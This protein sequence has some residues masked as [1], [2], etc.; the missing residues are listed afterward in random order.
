MGRYRIGLLGRLFAG[1][2]LVIGVMITAQPA[3]AITGGQRDE[4]HTNVGVVDSPPS[5]AG[6]AARAR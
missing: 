6:S 2:L 1:L 4:V 5:R 3:G